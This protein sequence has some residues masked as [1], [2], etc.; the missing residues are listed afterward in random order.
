MNISLF[1]STASKSDNRKVFSILWVV[2]FVLY[3]PAIKAGEV[4]DFSGWLY[5][6]RYGYFWDFINRPDSLS[7]YQF[8]QFVCYC[9]YKVFGTNL[10]LWHLLQVSMH[11][12]NCLL[13]YLFCK[14][15]MEDSKVNEAGLI[16]FVG[17]F[18]FAAC[19]HNTEVIVHEPCYHYLQGLLIV[20]VILRWV[21]QYHYHQRAKLAWFAAIL[22][23]LSTYSLEIFYFTPWFTLSLAIY[24][25]F[26]LGYD[27]QIFRRVV[28]RFFVPQLLLYFAHVVVLYLVIHKY[29]AHVP[30]PHDVLSVDFL[31]KFPKYLFHVVFLGRYLP[32]DWRTVA[33][34]FCEAKWVL[35]CFYAFII[36]ISA[37][38]IFFLKGLAPK[39]KAGGLFFLWALFMVFIATPFVVP[40]LQLILFDRYTYFMEPFF[41]VL[42]AL[43]FSGSAIR[44]LAAVIF[45]AYSVANIYCLLKTNI[46]WKKSAYVVNRLVHEVPPLGNKIVLLLNP[47]ENMNGAL[48]VGSQPIS[49]WKLMY[50]LYNEKQI[51]N[52]V[53]DVISYN[54]LSVDDGAHVNVL[55]DSTL[56]VTLNQW[57]TWWWYRYLG[58]GSRENEVFKLELVDPGHSYKLTLKRPAADYILLYEVSAQWKVVDW[59]KKMADQY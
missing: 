5:T 41:Y 48:M 43:L 20:L 11:S 14:K 40:D 21:Q 15:V 3:L 56:T 7:L 28:L 53:Y 55:N 46:Y 35:G 52:P 42:L 44:W 13:I 22:Y 16:A 39:W 29:V 32:L 26:A 50:N 17:A 31:S 23:F 4:G 19:P 25:R 10:I 47:P 58:A 57:G 54:L 34:H 45:S 6:I 33:Y 30:P 1:R 24:Y 37:Y 2:V 8:T 27:K 18:L 38:L 12:V 9:I 49:V 36:G 59:N 51:T